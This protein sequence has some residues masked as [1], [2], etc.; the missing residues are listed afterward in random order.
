MSEIP[1]ELR[2]TAEH[3]WA[4][5]GAGNA[6]RIG[7]TDYAQNSLGD[8]VFV[9]VHS[10]DDQVAV[11]DALGEVES[12]KSVSDLYAPVAGRVSARNEALDDNPELLNSD[13]YGEGWVA[14]IEVEDVSV[15]ESLLD[16]D[17]YRGVV[18][19]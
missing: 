7:I 14:E 8:I 3:E 19:E 6:V 10:L 12:T 9:S 17:A 18:A 1:S 5:P 2:Y 16:A 11:G 15:L 13:P 4:R